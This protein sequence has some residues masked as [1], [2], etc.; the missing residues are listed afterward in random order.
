MAEL[1]YP[2]SAAILGIHEDIVD[3]QPD[4]Q[5]GVR[6]PAAI[7]SALS[8]VSV[9]HFGQAPE[10][11][12]ETATELLRLLVAEHPFVDG[13]KRTALNTVVVLYEMNGHALPY[14]DHRI[15]SILKRFGIDATGVDTAA[16]ATYLKSTAKPLSDAEGCSERVRLADRATAATGD[17]RVAA[18]RQL[19]SL[20]RERNAETYERLATE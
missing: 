9:G 20:D 4:S 5:R 15:R 8:T 1:T 6:T 13:N 17:E 16:V 14:D 7:Q 2:D 18:I 11:L 19:A 12:H 10:T 3:G